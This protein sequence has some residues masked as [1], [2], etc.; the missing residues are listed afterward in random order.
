MINKKRVQYLN[1]EKIKDKPY[2]IYWMQSSQRVE[3]NHAL[4]YAIS[5]ANDL[6]KPLL[7]YFGLTDE[8]PDA[9]SRHYQFMIEGLKEVKSE[10]KKRNIKIIIRVISPEKGAI[11]MAEYA[12]LMVVDRGYLRIE[13][14][15]RS[16]VAANIN[17]PLVQVE[18]N[19]VVPIEEASQKEEYSAA[20]IRNKINNLL[21]LYTKRFEYEDLDN[22]SLSVVL[23]FAEFD[24]NSL[25][26]LNIESLAPSNYYRGGTSEAKKWLQ[27]FI[28]Q[29]LND[30]DLHRNDP[31]LDLQ[32][33]LSPYLHFGQISP[34]YIFHNLVNKNSSAF[35]EELIIRR[36][37]AINFVYYN[38]QYDNYE[39]LPS[40]ALKSLEKHRNDARLYL[41][42]LNQL[43]NYQTHDV[44]W[45]AA[46]REMVITGKMHGYMRM[47]WGKK[48]IEWSR[49]P[50]TAYTTLVYLNNKYSLDGRDPNG[51][52]GIA[53]CFGKHDRPWKER[54]IFGMVRYMNDK[55]LSRK[56]NIDAYVESVNK[57]H[58]NEK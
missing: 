19:V 32:S 5:R 55:G 33:N 14:E 36:E 30:Y 52:A 51:Y 40:W 13:R 26:N 9:N 15:W 27:L 21:P 45:N 8:Y 20:T 56:F 12:A 46:Q 44:Y 50:E 11:E 24:L 43:E 18:T 38:K 57:L 41:Y 54:D 16:E 25:L 4:E 58:K 10:L 34:V 22:S 6:S 49:S 28:D 42:N 7:V 39:S 29:K 31:S 47:Y 2:V 1:N 37:L 17:I 3:Y 48:I 35:L 53:W 23:S